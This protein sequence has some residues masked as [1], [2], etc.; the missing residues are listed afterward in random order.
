MKALTVTI[1]LSATLLASALG[2]ESP[3]AEPKTLTIQQVTYPELRYRLESKFGLPG[4]CM[5]Y[6]LLDQDAVAALERRHAE[7][8]FPQLQKQEAAFRAMSSH[9]GLPTNRKLSR[10]ERLSVYREYK[11]LL[12]AISIAPQNRDD[13]RPQTFKFS[14]IGEQDKFEGTISEKNGIIIERKQPSELNCALC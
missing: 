2:A 10:A 4:V 7:E 14:Y 9:L 12:C 11:I 5:S 1:L 8:A 6:S 3:C 13:T